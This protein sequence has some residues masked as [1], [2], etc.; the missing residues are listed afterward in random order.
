VLIRTFKNIHSL[1]TFLQMIFQLKPYSIL[2]LA[3]FLFACGAETTGD[4][5]TSGDMSQFTKDEKFNEAHEI[6]EAL[7]FKGTGKMITFETA[8]GTPGSAYAI[9]NDLSSNKALFVIHEWWGLNDHI[10]QEADKLYSEL[11]DVN[12]IALDLYDGKV[13][14]NPDDAGKIMG[15]VKEERLDAIIKGA[16]TYVGKDAKVGTIGWCFGGGWSL[17]SSILAG[18]QGAGCVMYYGMPV[19]EPAKL[20][21][22]K[23]DVLGLFANKDEWITP[24][25]VSDFEVVMKAIGKNISTKEFEADHAF[26]NPSSPRYVEEAA[27]EANAM[28]LAFLKERL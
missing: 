16:L 23:A 21:P 17:K 28:A 10:K 4:S 24:K 9:V 26:A 13:T 8:D 11:K 7:D 19:M 22:I 14:D 25:V 3:F 1:K 20:A 18:D 5:K 2:F 15:S 27:Q 6:P 12:I